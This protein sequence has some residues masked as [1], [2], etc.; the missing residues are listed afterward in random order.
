MCNCIML[1]HVGTAR[2]ASHMGFEQRPTISQQP[3][4][5]RSPQAEDPLFSLSFNV[6]LSTQIKPHDAF[7]QQMLRNLQVR[8]PASPCLAP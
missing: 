8:H 7:G 2:H 6:A 4:Q 1:S 5:P 3:G